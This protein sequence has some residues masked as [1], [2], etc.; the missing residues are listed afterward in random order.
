MLTAIVDN[1]ID[2]LISIDELG[3]IES[4]NR[5]CE[6][7]FGYSQSEVLGHN[8]KMLMPEPYHSGHD[9]YL[10]RY[11][12][13]GEARII[14]TAGREVSAKRK[15][16]SVF[17]M[18]LSVSSFQVAGTRHFSGIIR[19][20]TS[21]KQAEAQAADFTMALLR[22]NQAL[23]EFAY[24]ASHDLKAPLRVIDNASKW[25]EEDLAE[26][27]TGES[28]E[29]MQ[30]LRGRVKRMEKLLTDLLTYSRIGRKL[31][32]EPFDL[33]RGDALLA[34][35]LALLS[36]PAAFE[37]TVSPAFADIEVS[38][39]PLQQIFMNLIG[40]AIK[41]HDKQQGKIFV[42]VEPGEKKH[43]FFVSDDGPGIDPRFHARIFDM[44]QTLRPRDQVEGS[45][46]G[47]AMVR[48][49][50]ELS[51]GSVAV[52]SAE[53]AGST[54]RFT[55]PA[56]QPGKE[57]GPMNTT[58][59]LADFANPR[60][61]RILLVDDDDGDARAVQRAFSKARI[62]NPFRRAIDGIDALE[63]L[64]GENGKEQLLSPRLLLVDLNMPRMN[65]I[66]LV[67]AL[68]ADPIL[69]TLVVF[70]LTTSYRP[71]DM[72]AAYDLNVAGYILKEKAGEDFMRLCGLV[73]NFWRIVELP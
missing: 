72:A 42:G 53:G 52:E 22:S 58:T 56:N 68:R 62:A 64:R 24:A 18:D 65:G 2:G 3:N 61:L 57:G 37:I 32:E 25:I 47:L 26:H 5:A 1:V 12:H 41:H 27:L 10:S 29:N 73:D 4:F 28:L 21:R 6:R 20:I 35:V 11:N 40:N 60:Q 17:P 43:T 31:D 23:D 48:K 16:G 13:T 51:G 67:A 33:I 45:G 8:I 46:M 50:I 30:L 69:K 59:P 54:F 55:W 34:D 70:I 19:D 15:N 9:G 36:P 39:M 66:E 71:E 63:I 14:G 7:L 38:R 49:H 44:F